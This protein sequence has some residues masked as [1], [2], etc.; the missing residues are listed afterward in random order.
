MFK[1]LKQ[2]GQVLVF[3]ALLL[4]TLFMFVGAAADFGWYY[5]N[6]SRLQNA[7][8]AAVLA[9]AQ[10]LVEKNSAFE[11]YYVVSLATNDIPKDFD[12]YKNVSTSST[13][14]QPTTE[15]FKK[16]LKAGRDQAE[17]YAR[18]N[19]SDD[20]AATSTSGDEYTMGTTDSWNSSKA[21]DEHTC[22][23]I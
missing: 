11:N 14:Y 4:P 21:E 2:R 15:K 9:G 13:N 16:T 5:L 20:E 17:K 10:A 18:V 1:K 8:D 22:T 12:D 23:Q 3:Y 6:V 7:A 19:L